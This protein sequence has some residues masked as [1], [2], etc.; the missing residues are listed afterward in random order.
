VVIK[1]AK[2]I[3][4]TIFRVPRADEKVIS[5]LGKCLADCLKKLKLEEYT[6]NPSGKKRMVF[7]IEP[8]D[9]AYDYN[10]G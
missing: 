2:G 10:G 9:Y 6:S 4:I 3:R 8:F 7:F 1:L 5:A